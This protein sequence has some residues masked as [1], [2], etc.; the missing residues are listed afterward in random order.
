MEVIAEREAVIEELKTR[1][2]A[3]RSIAIG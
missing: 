3:L 2:T 1:R